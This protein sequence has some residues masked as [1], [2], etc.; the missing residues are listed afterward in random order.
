MV[1]L[2]KFF[3]SFGGQ[4]KWSLVVLDSWSSYTV[5]VVW[6]LAWA[7]AA[8][9]ILDK[10][11]PCRGGRISRFDCRLFPREKFYSNDSRNYTTRIC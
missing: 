9:V 2:D 8:L 11:F 6:E 7:D 4:K 10:W 1:V 3:F 5:T